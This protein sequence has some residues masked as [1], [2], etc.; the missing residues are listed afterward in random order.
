[1]DEEKARKILGEG[2]K[3]RGGL[4]SISWYL[5]WLVGEDSCTLDGVFEVEELEAI[6][7]WMKNKKKGE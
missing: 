7:W 4:F 5:E 1:M 2:I 6:A 3:A